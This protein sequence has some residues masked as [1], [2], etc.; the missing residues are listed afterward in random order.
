MRVKSLFLLLAALLCLIL[1]GCETVQ[2]LMAAGASL[3]ADA[4]VIS[5]GQATAVGKLGDSFKEITPEQEYYIGRAVGATLVT[6]YHPWNVAAADNYLNLT[7]Q[8]LAQFSARPQT[9]GGYHFLVLD[10]DEINAFAA[11]GGLIFVSRGLLRCCP[12]EDAVAA[13]LAH[14]IAHVEKQHGLQSIKKSRLSSAFVLL[15]TESAKAYGAQELADLTSAFE[16]SINDTVT[17]MVNHGYSR[18]FEY[19][20]DA[21]AVTILRRAGYDPAALVVMLETMQTRMHPGDGGFAQTHPAPGDRISELRPLLPRGIK[22]AAA[23]A[24]SRQ[25]RFARALKGV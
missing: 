7:G 25:V 20:A 1:G 19:E 15:G 8:M 3:A 18:S 9:F 13:V 24:E 14:E 21:A 2:S 4:G 5:Q 23:A 12:T 16:G 11:P 17:T 10:S 6:D 22:T